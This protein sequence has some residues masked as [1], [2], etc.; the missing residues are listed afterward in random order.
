MHLKE[1]I[2]PRAVHTL[3]QRQIYP[4][5]SIPCRPAKV[6]KCGENQLLIPT[7]VPQNCFHA[8]KT[9]LHSY[10]SAPVSERNPKLHRSTLVIQKTTCILVQ[11]HVFQVE[12]LGGP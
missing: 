5:I 7:H 12:G 11:S 4:S 10:E 8:S 6:L 3:S 9:T 2:L 1:H